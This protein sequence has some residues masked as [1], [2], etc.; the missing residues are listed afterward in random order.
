[1][2]YDF[3]WKAPDDPSGIAGYAYVIDTNAATTPATV[4]LSAGERFVST[5]LLNKGSYFL[6]IRAI[7][8]L[9]NVS[10]VTHLPFHI[11][12]VALV[13][14]KIVKRKGAGKISEKISRMVYNT[15][16]FDA[17]YD[18]LRKAENKIEANDYIY[19]RKYLNLASVIKPNRMETFLLLQ[20]IQKQV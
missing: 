9:Y 18:Y 12:P 16:S 3:Y 10:P 4:N 13:R 15:R 17:F 1:M 11:K 20:T 7:D 6:H 2:Y 5:K 19:A 8:T 14:K